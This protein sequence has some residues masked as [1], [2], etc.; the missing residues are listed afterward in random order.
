VAELALDT[1]EEAVQQPGCPNLYWA[2]TDLPHPLVAVRKGFQGHH[3]M[4]IADL[5]PLRDDSAMTEDEVEEV[6]S[7]LSGRIGY[8]REQAGETPRNL[9]AALRAR[10]KD[11]AQVRA[12]RRRLTDAVTADARTAGEGLYQRLDLAIRI[13]KFPP[14]Q[15]VLLDEKRA[16]EGRLDEGMKLLGPAPWQIDAVLREKQ[17]KRGDS[18]LADL[19]P[20]FLKV[21]RAQA[22]VEQRVDLLRHVEALRLYAAAHGG[23]LPARL[24]ELTVPLP[25][26]PFTGK[27]FR[28]RA[29]GATAHIGGG[30]PRDDGK[31]A[32]YSVH[33]YDVTV[34]K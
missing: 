15:L 25:D 14:M 8:A 19:L 1:L 4:V 5:R 29:D 33:L 12:L 6:V 20:D 3:T 17:A 11:E 16:Y 31:G 26:D 23:R 18:L 34:R 9:R 21:R 24:A 28:Y 22:R 2:L 27:P 7:R 30:S 32:A 10:V 13:Q